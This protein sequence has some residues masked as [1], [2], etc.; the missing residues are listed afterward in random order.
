ME[1]SQD[2]ESIDW[3][4]PELIQSM[5]VD[6]SVIRLIDE[7]AT[8]GIDVLPEQ[9]Q[10]LVEY[11]KLVLIKN[12][13]L[14]LTAIREWDKALILHLV[15][16]LTFLPEFDDQPEYIRDMPFLDMGCG[17]GFPGIPLAIMRP[18][19]IG[20]LC[21]SVK[22]K[23]TAVNEFIEE[24]GLMNQLSTTSERLEVY[25][26]YHK[27]EFGCITA[28]AVS[29]LPVLLEY[30]AP[31]L[32]REGRLIV[33][34]GQPTEDE[35]QSGEK[36]AKVCGFRLHSS[37]TVTL[38]HDMGQRTML[39]YRKVQE[40]AYKLPRAIGMAAKEPLV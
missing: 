20:E 21:D 6:E 37:R 17:A 40:P 15:D 38:P 16:S 29:S 23:I 34:K 25:A 13:S 35:L 4:N 32:P 33:S 22:K 12:C 1:Q 26:R 19:R 28:R 2:M 5:A 3:R 27:H 8:L 11:L 31:F 36:A 9:A 7:C 39:V 10:R 18:L 30:A 24:L 14:N